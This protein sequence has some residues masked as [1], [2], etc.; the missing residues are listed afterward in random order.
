MKIGL[1]L[2]EQLSAPRSAD[3]VVAQGAD[4]DSRVAVAA[5]PTAAASAPSRP[6]A[7]C[8]SSAG[9]TISRLAGA[10]SADFDAGKVQAIQAAIREGRFTVDCGAIADRLIAEAATMVSARTH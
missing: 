6:A 5:A 9:S 2:I 4:R 8:L 3:T 10:G 1:S 7:V